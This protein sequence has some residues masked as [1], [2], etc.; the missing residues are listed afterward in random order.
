M[1]FARRPAASRRSTGLASG[2]TESIRPDQPGPEIAPRHATDL[3]TTSVAA[4]TAAT[5]G[6]SITVGWQV[7]DQST[8]RQ[9]QLARQRL[10]LRHADDHLELDPAGH[11]PHSGGLGANGTY[12]G[13]LTAALPALRLGN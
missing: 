12:N 13:S 5:D 10:P 9:R 7:N 6:Q 1:S 2:M 8:S 11:R 4:P 3:A